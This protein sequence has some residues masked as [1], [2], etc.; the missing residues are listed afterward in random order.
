ML[1]LLKIPTYVHSMNTHAMTRRAPAIR[2]LLCTMV[3]GVCLAAAPGSPGEDRQAQD[4]RTQD[5]PAPGH[6]EPLRQ[7]VADDS[8]GAEAGP[9]LLPE[10]SF[11]R[12]R[13]GRLGQIGS[14]WLFFFDADETGKSPP[15]APIMQTTDLMEMKRLVETRASTVTFVINAEVFVYRGQNYLLPRSFTVV[16]SQGSA[17]PAANA[18]TTTKAPAKRPPGAPAPGEPTASDLIK[19]METARPP[20]A[21]LPMRRPEGLRETPAGLRREGEFLKTRR[22]RLERRT[23]SRWL[24]VFDNDP[25]AAS[26][27]SDRPR[28]R[29]DVPMH[30]LPCLTLERMESVAMQYGESVPL[31]VSGQV[32]VYEGENYILPTMLT[33]DYADV[34]DLKPAQ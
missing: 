12:E 26:A 32:F 23:A 17:A 13:R 21:R 25:P 4:R 34:G 9:A 30:P 6:R 8:A 3:S 10:G 7:A 1:R 24:L 29:P 31:I 22:A 15:P 33:L 14:E 20:A 28:K 27:E 18:S 11:L 5:R 19:G 2:L 16:A